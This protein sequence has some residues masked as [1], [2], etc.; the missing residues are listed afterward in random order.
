MLRVC[1]KKM[2]LHMSVSDENKSICDIVCQEI[3][4]DLVKGRRRSDR[5]ITEKVFSIIPAIFKDSVSPV[6][7]LEVTYCL[8]DIPGCNMRQSLGSSM[9]QAYVK[10][11]KQVM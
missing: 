3:P 8:L 6:T 5:R 1:E 4:S 2:A 10:M 11:L 7:Y 9:Q